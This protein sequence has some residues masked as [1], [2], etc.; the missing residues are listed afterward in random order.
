MNII[1]RLKRR[2]SPDSI[3]YRKLKYYKNIHQGKRAIVIGNGPSLLIDDLDK[4][5]NEITFASN[6]IFLA[7]DQTSWRPTYLSCS[8]ILVAKNNKDIL[9]KLKLTK[10]FGDSVKSEF[11]NN[12][13]IWLAE[14]SK[15][16]FSKD[17][18]SVVYGGY[19][20]IYHQLQ[21][22]AY[23]GIKEIF[24]IGVDYSFN[25][26][27]P[28]NEICMHGEIIVSNGE[29]N[30]FH[31]NYRQPGETWTMPRLDKQLE[32]FKCAEENFE[33]KIYNASR[34]TKLDV[35]EKINFDNLFR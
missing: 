23:M 27:I 4:L 2:Y 1:S 22:A 20:V 14:S 21:L 18:L 32:A 19:S 5:H 30:H 34:I 15:L 9:N 31:K 33:G 3:N 29:I 28:S 25:I 24:L 6:K 26:P 17:C 16:G 35:F 13:I 10:I 12:K 7:F 8:D 11:N